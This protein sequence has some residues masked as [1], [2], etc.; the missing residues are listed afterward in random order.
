MLNNGIP[1]IDLFA[2]PGGLGEGFSSVVNKKGK[3]IFK[4]A[5]SVEMEKF[6]HQ[7]LTLRSFFRQFLHK[8]D[9]CAPRAYYQYLEG[10]IKKEELFEAFP[11]EYAAAKKEAVCAELGDEKQFPHADFFDSRIKKALGGAKDWLLIGGPPCQAYSLVGRARK[12]GGGGTDEEIEEKRVKFEEDPKHTLYQ[13]YLRI[14]ARHSP[15]VFVMENVKGILSSKLDGELIFPKILED[16][17]YPKKA[18][19]YKWSGDEYKDSQYEILSLVQPVDEPNKDFVIRSE[20]YGIPQARH[21]VILLGIRKDKYKKR[22]GTV[23]TLEKHKSVVGV[24]SAI[25]D[26]PKLRSGLSKGPDDSDTWGKVLG[27]I[28]TQPWLG[29]LDAEV[30]KELTL[31]AFARRRPKARGA[32]RITNRK[33]APKNDWY[34][35]D[36]LNVI[37][38]HEV[39]SHIVEDIYRYVY[40]SAFGF[41]HGFSPKLADFPDALLPLH[42][43]VK[44]GVD[45][46][47]FADRFRVQIGDKP[48]TTVTCHISKDGHYFIHPDPYQ[49]RSLTVRE[50][51][52]LQTFP[53]NYF[54]EGPRTAQYH[55]VGNAVPPLLAKQIGEIVAKLFDS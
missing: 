15:S 47:K 55:Q 24:L 50:A 44:Q 26:L 13:E 4:I 54:F 49:A 12:T 36:K 2:G 9:G 46:A 20:E 18:I 41:V 10:S 34:K 45:E 39:R 16:L 37:C 28:V 32:D 42:K 6:A 33:A 53:D 30:R 23:A 27:D 31:I 35:D 8:G 48:S 22:K 5:L 17:K 7:T 21:R 1:I 38:N 52:R 29:E 43:N 11:E 19:A 51:A 40:V 14:I 25:N 3:R